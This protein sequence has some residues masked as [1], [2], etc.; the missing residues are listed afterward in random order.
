MTCPKFSYLGALGLLYFFLFSPLIQN[1]F[2]QSPL[3]INE[4]LPHPSTGSDWVELYNL[5][6][7]T[8]NLSGFRLEDTSTG[9]AMRVFPTGTQVLSLGYVVMT[10]GSRLTDTNDAVNLKDNNGNL[11]DSYSYQIGPGIDKSFGRYPDGVN[12]WI[13]FSNPS[14]NSPNL[15][16]ISPTPT[17]IIT[18]IPTQTPFPSVI[19]TSTPIDVPTQTPTVIPVPTLSITPIIIPSPSPTIS[20]IP[21][22]TVGPTITSILT[23]LPTITL[24]PHNLNAWWYNFWNTL[25]QSFPRFRL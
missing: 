5:G 7:E 16:P 11:L 15:L 6:S 13:I 25:W 3:V 19:P 12:N 2:A 14:P 1:E 22:S 9:S 4:I 21:T 24:R 20:S 17:S 23:P 18:I 8:M 10:V